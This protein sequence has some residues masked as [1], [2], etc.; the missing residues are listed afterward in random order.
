MIYIFGGAFDPPH[1]GH[2]AIVKSILAKKNPEKIVIIPSSERDD[3][4]YHIS[5]TDRLALLHIF[6]EELDDKRVTIDDF[7]IKNWKGEMITRDVDRYAREQYGEDRSHIFGTDVISSMSDWDNEHYA[8]ERVKKLFIP[9]PFPDYPDDNVDRW[10]SVAE[11]QGIKNFDILTDTHI[12]AISS[13]EIR[14]SIPGYTE[15]KTLYSYTPQ[16]IIP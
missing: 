2:A 6:V 12:P 5:D 14:T 4:Q 1:V 10:R 7:F 15:L 13:T 3:K 8:A 16:Y 9:R 11:E